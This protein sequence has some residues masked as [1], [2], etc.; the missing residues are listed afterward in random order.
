MKRLLPF[1]AAVAGV[2]QVCRDSQVNLDRQEGPAVLLEPLAQQ[3][4]W[5]NPA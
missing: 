4:G 2:L 1:H 3:V 5:P